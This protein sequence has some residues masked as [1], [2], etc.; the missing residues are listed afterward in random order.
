MRAM[1][2]VGCAECEPFLTP[3]WFLHTNCVV[4]YPSAFAVKFKCHFMPNKISVMYFIP[5]SQNRTYCCSFAQNFSL[6]KTAMLNRNVK[7]AMLNFL[8]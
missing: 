5:H 4:V 2:V 1:E 7:T 6:S 3:P 8:L